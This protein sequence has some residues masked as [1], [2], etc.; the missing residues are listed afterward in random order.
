MNEVQGGKH[1]YRFGKHICLFLFLPRIS[2]MGEYSVEAHF[3]PNLEI[4]YRIED[5]PKFQLARHKES[6]FH[7]MMPR[8]NK[9]RGK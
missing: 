2:R 1:G 8:F 3:L 4:L 5:F 9:I 6:S 7:K